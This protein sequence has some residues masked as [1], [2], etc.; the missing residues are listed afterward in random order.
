MKS[1]Q[2]SLTVGLALFLAL[3]WLS[4]PILAQHGEHAS[5]SS[6][7]R[8]K[9][10]EEKIHVGKKGEL[11]IAMETRIADVLLPVG[12]Y[13]FQHVIDGEDHVAVFTK[14]AGDQA[15]QEVARLKCKV[16]PLGEI[17]RYTEIHT[18]LNANGERTIT[19]IHVQGENVRH[20]F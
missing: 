10:Q 11:A 19:E 12:K 8:G 5:S 13:Q 6:S 16:Q 7:R 18:T 1:K 9:R 3:G 20:V 2:K 4:I 17:A 15:G 14:M